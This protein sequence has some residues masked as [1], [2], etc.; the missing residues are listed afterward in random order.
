MCRHHRGQ[1]LE[2]VLGNKRS[3]CNEKP[4][5]LSE[6]EPPAHRNKRKS[7]CSKEGPV[8]PNKS[9]SFLK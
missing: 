1:T 4:E 3:H 7:K 9:I 8:Q 2:P 6:E 5:G